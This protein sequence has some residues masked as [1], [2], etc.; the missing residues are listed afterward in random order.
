[1]VGSD[2]GWIGHSDVSRVLSVVSVICVCVFP[3]QSFLCPIT[4]LEILLKVS[5]IQN[6]NSTT[7]DTFIKAATESFSMSYLT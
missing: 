7:I 2:G 5:L 1:M 3:H 6:F 4:L